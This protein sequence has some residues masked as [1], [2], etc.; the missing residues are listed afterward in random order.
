LRPLQPQHQLN[1]LFLAQTFKIA[2]AHTSR[3]SANPSWR[4]GLGNYGFSM[5]LATVSVNLRD[6]LV[7]DALQFVR[8]PAHF[9]SRFFDIAWV[10]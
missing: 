7:T 6:I 2:A 8:I 4:K 5:P 1:Q 9:L 10:G 3:E